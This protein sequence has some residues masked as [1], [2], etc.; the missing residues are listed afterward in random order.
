MLTLA[1]GT[2]VLVCPGPGFGK[3]SAEVV[4]PGD[5]VTVRLTASG[6]ALRVPAASV[7]LVPERTEPKPS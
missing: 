5:I 3:L 7:Q 1:V 2:R 4:R 6:A